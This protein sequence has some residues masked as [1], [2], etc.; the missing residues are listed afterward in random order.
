MAITRIFS[1]ISFP[2]AE[3]VALN[4]NAVRFKLHTTNRSKFAT[5]LG[6]SLRAFLKLTI[7]LILSS[8]VM[9]AQSSEPTLKLDDFTVTE[10]VSL[11]P[12]GQFRM[13][14]QRFGSAAITVNGIIYIFGGCASHAR[15]LD[16]IERFDPGTGKSQ[17][18][19]KMLRPR[20][21]HQAVIVGTKVY[22]FGGDG[23]FLSG[24]YFDDT[25]ETFDVESG[26]SK[27]GEKMPEARSLFAAVAYQESIFIIGG[28]R[29]HAGLR[30]HTN[31]VIV[32]NTT[33]ATWRD[34]EPMP[35]P[36]LPAAALVD[37][38]FI[39]VAGGYNGRANLAVVE[40]YDP[41]AHKWIRLPEL[42][43][44][45]SAH[46]MVYLSNRL[47][48]F[49]DYDHPGEVMSYDLRTKRSQVIPIEFS[50]ARHS[51]ITMVDDVIYVIGGKIDDDRDA[52]ESIQAFK[53][54][55]GK[56]PSSTLGGKPE[57]PANRGAPK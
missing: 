13:V 31:R 15:V 17:I 50:P 51:S 4:P 7:G 25:M 26:K 37:G 30:T 40:S 54:P 14:E 19:G 21:W 27:Y 23:R 5:L 6:Q 33:D 32:Y 20:M 38:G 39:V 41:R 8:G 29:Q 1:L 46:S 18:I 36:R 52:L 34:G 43:T 12:A 2:V 48:I 24:G 55:K 49:G 3:P 11:I 57:P 10:Q 56:S 47:F 28:T 22:I 9:V 53:L 42:S 16:S 44:E 35:T 45:R